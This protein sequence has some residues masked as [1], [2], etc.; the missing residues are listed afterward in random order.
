MTQRVLHCGA[1]LRDKTYATIE[2]WNLLENMP[3]NGAMAVLQALKGALQRPVPSE[4]SGGSS[5]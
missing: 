4:E 5:G 2:C 1:D 3:E